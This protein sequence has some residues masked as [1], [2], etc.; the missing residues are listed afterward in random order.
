MVELV[1]YQGWAVLFCREDWSE[2][3]WR[4]ARDEV[5]TVVSALSEEN[6]HAAHVNWP[7][8]GGSV[9]ALNGWDDSADAPLRILRRVAELVPHS[10]GELVVFPEADPTS[11]LAQRYRMVKGILREEGDAGPSTNHD[12]GGFGGRQ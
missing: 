8:N 4:H 10:Y 7:A 12:A 1:E 3:Q 11:P 9:V 6:G 2:Q 5:S